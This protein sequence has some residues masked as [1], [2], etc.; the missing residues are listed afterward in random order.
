[1]TIVTIESFFT[2]MAQC[3][4]DGDH[5]SVARTRVYPGA[6]YLEDEVIVLESAAAFVAFMEN[7]CARNYQM[8][9]RRVQNRVVAQSLSRTNNY[10]VWVVWQHFDAGGELLSATNARYI[11]RDSIMG[12]PEV[13]LVEYIDMP[14][15]YKEADLDV[16]GAPR[17][18]SS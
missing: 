8:G 14:A 2:A 16:M 11:C 3:F 15:C 18:Q 5:R 9:V 17:R 10:S 1:M 4:Q 6:I 13:Q 7:H 12:V